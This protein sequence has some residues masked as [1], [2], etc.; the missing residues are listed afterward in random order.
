[1]WLLLAA[2]LLVAIGLI[3]GVLFYILGGRQDDDA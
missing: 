2:G 3:V 1:M